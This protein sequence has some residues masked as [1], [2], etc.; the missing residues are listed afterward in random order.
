MRA[1]RSGIKRPNKKKLLA[2]L[3]SSC[4]P[5]PRSKPGSAKNKKVVLKVKHRR[6]RTF[7]MEDSP[8]GDN[9]NVR[10]GKRK[11][12]A[13][14]L[15]QRQYI[16]DLPRYESDDDLDQAPRRLMGRETGKSGAAR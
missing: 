3:P 2:N 10:R 1:S 14:V 5:K 9:G 15:L 12:K 13:N 4:Q 16:S 7:A 6:K 8:E 11:R